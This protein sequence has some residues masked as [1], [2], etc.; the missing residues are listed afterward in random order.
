MHRLTRTYIFFFF[1]AFAGS[2]SAQ[3]P[4]LDLSFEQLLDLEVAV[5]ST[6]TENILNSPAIVSRLDVQQIQKMG[7]HTL[8][9]LISMLPGVQVQ[10]SGIGTKTIMVRGVFEAFNQKVLFTL[11]GVPYWQPAHGD[12]PLQGIP[13]EAIDRIEVIRGPGTVFHGSNASA[14]VIN[15]VTR[16]DDISSVSGTLTSNA[17]SGI[18]FYQQFPVG[19][20]S[21][22]IS[23]HVSKGPEYQAFYSARPQPAFF[24]ELPPPDGVIDKKEDDHSIM[25]KFTGKNFSMLFHDFRS[26]NGGL[27]AAASVANEA[28]MEQVGRLFHI[29]NKWLREEG[30]FTAYA[31]YNNYHLEIPTAR[32]FGGLIDGEQNFADGDDNF[33]VR[34]G[35]QYISQYSAH[36]E[37]VVGIE[38][39]RRST[40]T[41]YHT[42]DDGSREIV[43]MDAQETDEWSVYGQWL[44]DIDKHR[45]I[46]GVRAVD[47]DRSGSNFLPRLSWLYHLN[48]L[49]TIKVVYSNGF[50]SPNFLQQSIR[51][52]PNVITGNPELKAETIDTVD[53]AY[54]YKDQNKAFIANAY[55]LHADNF[56]Q[57]IS[58]G[59]VV[60]YENTEHFDRYGFEL[61]FQYTTDSIVWK[62]NINYQPDANSF[63]SEDFARIFIPK[64]TAS[65]GVTKQLSD[66]DTIGLS[67]QHQGPRAAAG[68]FN[69]LNLQFTRR[70]QNLTLMFSAHN[71]L[72][73]DYLVQ[74]VQDFNPNRL[75]QSGDNE[76]S[77]RITARWLW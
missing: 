15:I 41:Y 56:I 63:D 54:T 62:S 66:S 19:E 67:Y 52:P 30:E 5:A 42:A 48:D 32:L 49:S 37:Y 58:N 71:I 73:D 34:A 68:T 69:Y 18:E 61:D 25:L 9:D 65:F 6:K 10:D 39:E 70:W 59:F 16:T 14:G 75:I 20:N 72:S 23:G 64:L 4:P 28:K 21:V 31:D 60:T 3:E 11:D 29:K 2:A 50:N 47:N 13:L 35:V 8:A 27:A 12:V 74:D 45:L 40:G 43:V 38:G 36:S 22:S 1:F 57:R 24:P 44:S 46:V 7:I 76:P 26:E 33:R 77:Y 51:I 53:I 17:E 55:W